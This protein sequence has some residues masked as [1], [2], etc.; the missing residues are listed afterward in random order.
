MKNLFGS[1]DADSKSLEFLTKV[2][3]RN[4]LPGFDYLEFKGAIENLSK[5]HSD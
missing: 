1:P 2:I 4:N 5:F 3:E